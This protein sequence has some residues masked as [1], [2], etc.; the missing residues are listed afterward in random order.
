MFNRAWDF[1]RISQFEWSV[2]TITKKNDDV[3]QKPLVKPF[4]PA[5]DKQ[6]GIPMITPLPRPMLPIDTETRLNVVHFTRT[7]LQKRSVLPEDTPTYT[8]HVRKRPK[9]FV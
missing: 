7:R 9:S 8:A 1:S 5:T 3:A 6:N 2:D 4:P